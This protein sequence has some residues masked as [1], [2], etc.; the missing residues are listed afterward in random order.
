MYPLNTYLDKPKWK[1]TICLTL[2]AVVEGLAPVFNEFRKHAGVQVPV[3]IRIGL[4]FKKKKQ[5]SKKQQNW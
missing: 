1:E 4:S 3:I 2:G 5:K